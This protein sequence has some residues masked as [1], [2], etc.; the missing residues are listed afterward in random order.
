LFPE[1]YTDKKNDDTDLNMPTYE[2]DENGL[3]IT[4]YKNNTEKKGF[5]NNK[6]RGYGNYNY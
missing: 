3:L 6:N 5:N 2:V 1:G 4:K